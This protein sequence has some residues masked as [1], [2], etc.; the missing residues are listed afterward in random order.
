[1][2]IMK[3]LTSFMLCL[4]L[5]MILSGCVLF[6]TQQQ[7]PFF[8]YDDID[9]SEADFT[10]LI[11]LLEPVI[12]VRATEVKS[13]TPEADGY[14]HINAYDFHR[15]MNT[16]LSSDNFLNISRKDFI[17]EYEGKRFAISATLEYCYATSILDMT[18]NDISVHGGEYFDY[19]SYLHKLG[20]NSNM[21][22]DGKDIILYGTLKDYYGLIDLDYEIIN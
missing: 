10:E 11:S 21:D 17:N 2:K 22:Y 18:V 1:M 20:V 16:T 4:L 13:L 15:L 14:I 19:R 5:T 9:I 3:H 12:E 8:D 7:I 6:Q